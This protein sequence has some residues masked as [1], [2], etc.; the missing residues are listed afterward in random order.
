M[1]LTF[2]SESGSTLP[3]ARGMFEKTAGRHP[4]KKRWRGIKKIVRLRIIGRWRRKKETEKQE[5][6]K[7]EGKNK[8][9][10]K[11]TVPEPKPANEEQEQAQE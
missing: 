2:K 9:G 6:N 8:N 4:G 11:K 1:N 10:S 7:E 5:T 3:D